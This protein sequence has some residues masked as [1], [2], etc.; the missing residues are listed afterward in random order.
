MGDED[1]N[2]KI[3][4]GSI[5][6]VTLL[7]LV[8]FSSAVGYNV[9]KNTKEEIFKD[10]Y[11]G[12]TPIAL[13]F[14]LIS[15]LRNHKDIENVETEDD[16]LQIIEGDEELNSIVE[17]LSNEDCACEDDSSKLESVFPIICILLFPLYIISWNAFWFRIADIPILIM[18]Q[19]GYFF[20]CDWVNK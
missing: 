13:I 11:D 18:M 20:G 12:F 16:V 10:E 7:T 6:A 14:Q 8:S 1:M 5:L 19:I 2:K 3:I 9:V 4:I 15:K 17:Q